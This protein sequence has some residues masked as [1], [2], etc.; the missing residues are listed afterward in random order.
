LDIGNQCCDGKHHRRTAKAKLKPGDVKRRV[1]AK[2]IVA[3]HVLMRR[4]AFRGY[5]AKLAPLK[6]LDF[7]RRHQR[8]GFAAAAGL[9]L[10]AAFPNFNLAGAAWVA[11]GLLLACAHGK[12][13]GA[14]WRIGYT[15]GLVFWLTS[16]SWLLEI[17]VT[18][19]PILG[20]VSLSAF[21]A[22]YPAFWVWLLAGKIGTGNWPQRCFW[23]LAGAALWVA[24]E[25][26]RARFLSGFPWNPL[27]ASQWRMT[28]LIQIASVTGVYGLSFLPVWVALALYSSALAMMRNPTRRYVWLGEIILP[29]IAVMTIFNLGLGHIRRA[30]ETD[31]ALR[32]TFIQPA[33]PQ[34]MI[35]DRSENTNRF[36]DLLALTETAL[37]NPT[38]LLLWPEA[39][40]PELNDETY[41]AVTNLTRSRHVWMLLNADD[42]REELDARGNARYDIFNAAYVFNP[43]GEWSGV[44]HKRQLVIFGEYIPLVD[45]LPFIKW[46]TPITGGYTAGDRIKRFAL[47]DRL[48]APLICFED[49]FPHHVRDHVTTDTDLMV[50]LT[51]DG[52]FGESAAHWQQAAASAF[53]AVENGIPLLRCCNNGI[54]SWFDGHGRMR[55]LF[56]DAAGS[57][58]GVGFANWEIPFH[59]AVNRQERTFYNQHGDWFG[60]GCV[61]WTALILVW[62]FKP[63]K[64]A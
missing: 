47:D 44:Y 59:T 62:R 1:R 27:G 41:A 46:F 43:Q 32:V 51:N 9:A 52:W 35:W 45:V 16:L 40:L 64:S 57:E 49:M 26:I 55:E 5:F 29:L 21:M 13:G 53:R 61:G 3:P 2:M 15:G 33:V 34:S 63:K 6:I 4:L 14:A 48:I 18:G 37:T 23:L 11:P 17:P 7:I 24:G 38:D 19:F 60:W 39:A 36:R 25:M 10:A 50:N 12:T 22:I 58:Y 20:W 31:A 54:T 8:H 42:Y 56:R 28:P 30:P